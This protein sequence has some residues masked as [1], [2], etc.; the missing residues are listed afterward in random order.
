[1][2]SLSF[3]DYSQS[4]DRLIFIM[5]K[6]RPECFV[7]TQLTCRLF[8]CVLNQTE[9]QT[10]VQDCK[11]SAGEIKKIH[12]EYLSRFSR[13]IRWTYV[14]ITPSGLYSEYLLFNVIFHGDGMGMEGNIL[15]V[16]RKIFYVF[17][18]AKTTWCTYEVISTFI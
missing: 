13:E 2:L 8:V 6:I 1:M 18:S 17:Y 9:M 14:K 15:T 10:S 4:Y 5:I 7:R 11:Y 16:F 12:M 3:L